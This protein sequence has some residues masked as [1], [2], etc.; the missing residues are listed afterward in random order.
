M[1][2]AVH[3]GVSVRVISRVERGDIGTV[4]LGRLVAI[5]TTLGVGAADVVPLL[6]ATG[7]TPRH[8]VQGARAKTR[9]SQSQKND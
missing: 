2:L 3:S 8:P 7:E 9:N 6:G 4:T 5:A 1:E